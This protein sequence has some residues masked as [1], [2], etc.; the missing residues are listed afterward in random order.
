[1]DSKAKFFIVGKPNGDFGAEPMPNLEAMRVCA[2]G[3]GREAN[4]DFLVFLFLRL[5]V[6]RLRPVFDLE[7][8]VFRRYLRFRPVFRDLVDFRFLRCV[9]RARILCRT[10]S[11]APV[12]AIARLRRGSA[13]NEELF[14]GPN[15]L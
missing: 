10:T 12:L 3:N 1:M 7:D 6:F 4:I 15:S 11:E 5:L 13:P 9:L 2:V 14:S 8:V